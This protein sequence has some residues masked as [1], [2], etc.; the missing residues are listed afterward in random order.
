MSAANDAR[1]SAHED[2]APKLPE[3]VSRLEAL[4]V[5]PHVVADYV[6]LRIALLRA[7]WPVLETLAARAGEEP[8]QR[9]GNGRSPNAAPLEPRDVPFDAKL[10][11]RLARALS[12][13]LERPGQAASFEPLLAA[14]DD[15]PGLL[16]GLACA[17]GWQ[18]QAAP[19]P[20]G[21]EVE[22][23]LEHLAARYE[24]TTDLLTFF[25]RLLAAPRG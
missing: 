6:R 15:D 14:A 13:A 7:Q 18:R 24:L 23:R 17:A 1:L 25:G 8:A 16:A 4:L 2:P 3:I 10:L 20:P 19:R 5:N 11:A 21:R 9:G 22:S 12:A